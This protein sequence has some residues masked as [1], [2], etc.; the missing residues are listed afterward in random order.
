MSRR[1]NL[2][3]HYHSL[4]EVQDIMNSMKT[5]AYIENHKLPAFIEAQTAV[6]TSI[7]QASRDLLSCHP[8][9]LPSAAPDCS[10]LILIGSERGFCG[11]FNHAL[12]RE[13]GGLQAKETVLISVG[14]K[15]NVLLEDNHRRFAALDGVSV[16]EEISTLI[17]Q[18]VSELS[19]L[20]Q[21]HGMLSVSCLYHD[22]D[23]IRLQQL[24]PPF[25]DLLAQPVVQTSPPLLN[26]TADALLL[27]LS[28]QYLFAVL[29]QILFISL[30]QENHFRINHLDGAVKYLDKQLAELTRQSY[31][32]RQ[33]EIIEEIEV[34]L[35]SAASLSDIHPGQSD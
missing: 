20:Q 32:L 12:A 9:I 18:L 31:A 26:M 17:Q 34:I 11:D 8:D 5:M 14:H 10:V 23:A 29:H 1:Q 16:A 2:D 24:L 30:L 15:L 4:K 22:Q 27:E 7:E 33:E 19:A 25:H 21:E 28:D 3:H 6:V 13:L 35:L